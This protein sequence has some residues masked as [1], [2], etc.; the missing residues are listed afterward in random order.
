MLLMVKCIGFE[1]S[2]F[3]PYFLVLSCSYI[4]DLAAFKFF[5]SKV[6]TTV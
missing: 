1:V 3:V 6:I 2:I 5:H 4:F